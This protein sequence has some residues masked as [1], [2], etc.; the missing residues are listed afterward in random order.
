[1]DSVTDAAVRTEGR[2]VVTREVPTIRHE[3][4]MPHQAS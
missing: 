1:M 4:G 2:L 3:Y